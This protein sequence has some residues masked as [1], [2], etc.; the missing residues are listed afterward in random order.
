PDPRSDVFSLG[1]VMFECITGRQV[2]EGDN[3]MA[4]LIK[5]VLSEIPPLRALRSDVPEPVERLVGRML[6]K[7]PRSRPADAGERAAEAEA[8]TA[9]WG[10]EEAA[11]EHPAAVATTVFFMRP[12]HTSERSVLTLNEQRV[13]SVVIADARGALGA[14]PSAAA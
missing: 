9:V 13:V 12:R 7:D 10:D 4:L 8:L 5:V 3:P 11:L 6:A 14:P 2:Y 1:C